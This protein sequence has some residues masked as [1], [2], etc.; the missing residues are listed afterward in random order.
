MIRMRGDLPKG[1]RDGIS[2]STKTDAAFVLRVLTGSVADSC[3]SE[4]YG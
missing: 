4:E 3:K 1:I 2:A